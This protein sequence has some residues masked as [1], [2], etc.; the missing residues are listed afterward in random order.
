MSK[1]RPTT[2]KASPRQPTTTFTER[3]EHP[4]Y[5]VTLFVR[6][7]RID[8]QDLSQCQQEYR[9]AVCRN[10]SEG[11]MLI[12]IE[13]HI[14]RGQ[15][16]EVYVSDRGADST[17]FGIVETVRTVRTPEVSRWS[18]AWTINRFPTPC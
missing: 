18:R 6:Y 8:L 15:A 13:T 1:P 12:E 17:I 5:H 14:P 2:E 10:I 9:H 3:R 16:L 4:R 7:R 11:G